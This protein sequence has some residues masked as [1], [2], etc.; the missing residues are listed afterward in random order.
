MPSASPMAAWR[1][2]I[3]DAGGVG[4]IFNTGMILDNYPTGL[5]SSFKLIADSLK[6]V[7]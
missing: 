3:A 1:A 2:G 7:S 6:A 4:R 5:A